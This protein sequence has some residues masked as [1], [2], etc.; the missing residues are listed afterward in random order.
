MWYQLKTIY[1]NIKHWHFSLLSLLTSLY[2]KKRFWVE[3]QI[4]GNLKWENGG[5]KRKKKILEKELGWHRK[6]ESKSL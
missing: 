3:L 1:R 6:G 4:S 5:K 2:E